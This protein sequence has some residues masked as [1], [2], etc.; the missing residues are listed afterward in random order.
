VKI[1]ISVHGGGYA[2]G[3]DGKALSFSTVRETVN[4]LV[5][6]NWTAADLREVDFNIEE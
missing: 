5:D 4:Y 6:R 1:T 3:E 2:L